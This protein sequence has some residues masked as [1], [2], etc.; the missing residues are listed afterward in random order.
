MVLGA[1]SRAS[2]AVQLTISTPRID[3]QRHADRTPAAN[4]GIVLALS[5]EVTQDFGRT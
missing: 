2:H 4:N 5:D 3:S 1:G